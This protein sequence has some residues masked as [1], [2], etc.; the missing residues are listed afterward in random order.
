VI[1]AKN[2]FGYKRFVVDVL[3]MGVMCCVNIPVL[4]TCCVTHFYLPVFINNQYYYLEVI[5]AAMG[6]ACFVV[7]SVGVAGLGAL[8]G[9]T[10]YNSGF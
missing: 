1:L 6:D 9:Y 3:M 4:N 2:V 10:V 8:S 7:L 5:T